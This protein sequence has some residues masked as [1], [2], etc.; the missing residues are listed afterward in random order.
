MSDYVRT[1]RQ[2]VTIGVTKKVTDG[3]LLQRR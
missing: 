3:Y 1:M 2:K